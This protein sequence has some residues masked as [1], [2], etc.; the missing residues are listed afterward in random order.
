MIAQRS[1]FGVD[2]SGVYITTDLDIK[3]GVRV[4]RLR[5]QI[6]L[7]SEKEDRTLRW[8]GCQARR[9]LAVC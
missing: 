2:Y 1:L 8:S 6:D 9:P 5:G 3:D 4:V 7:S